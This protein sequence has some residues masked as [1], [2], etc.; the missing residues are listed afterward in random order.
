MTGLARFQIGLKRSQ[1]PGLEGLRSIGT[2]LFLLLLLLFLLFEFLVLFR[3]H[4]VGDVAHCSNDR[5]QGDT[6]GM[7]TWSK[8]D[9]MSL[10]SCDFFSPKSTYWTRRMS[11]S[12]YWSCAQAERL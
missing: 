11:E 7:R 10:R 6:K 3:C 12:D 8:L 9:F 1:G 4:A 5:Q 2:K